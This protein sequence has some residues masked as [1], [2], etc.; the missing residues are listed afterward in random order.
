MRLPA[1]LALGLVLVLLVAPATASAK[2]SIAPAALRVSATKA[3]IRAAWKSDA[4]G[5]V[6]VQYGPT[7]AYG[8][9]ANVREPQP[10][11]GN[12]TDTFTLTGLTPGTVYHLRGHIHENN[13]VP[14]APTDTFSGDITFTTAPLG[15]SVLGQTADFTGAPAQN[16]KPPA[17]SVLSTCTAASPL[18]AGTTTMTVLAVYQNANLLLNPVCVT[19]RVKSDCLNLRVG[20]FV[21]AFASTATNVAAANVL[22]P[23]PKPTDAELQFAVP[24]GA[25]YTVAISDDGSCAAPTPYRI[26][27]N[28]VP[29][30]TPTVAT[31]NATL[32]GTRSATL[33]GSGSARFRP[34]VTAR[35]DYGL[36]TSYGKSIALGALPPTAA[37]LQQ[38]RRVTGL[39]PNRVYHARLVLIGPTGLIRG[40]DTTFRTLAKQ[41]PLAVR[42]GA[43][44]VRAAGNV[45]LRIACPATTTTCAG[46]MTL[47]RTTGNHARLGTKAFTIAGGKTLVVT[48]KLSAANRRLL[49][50][51]HTLRVAVTLTGRDGDRIA[52]PTGKRTVRLTWRG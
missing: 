39:L 28:A 8:K 17:A 29:L 9:V 18:V 49:K 4:L 43:V 15:P 37:T 11:T 36:T 51:R 42:T 13:P 12:G 32:V 6:Q 26:D 7:T 33:N 14:P 30:L 50:R 34:G 31:A 35:F 46:K 40:A 5:V 22:P 48:V 52:F 38:A 16:A 3:L 24:A 41:K 19:V 2:S 20:G 45:P 44:R 1:R 23:T 27:V 47:R 21:G 10:L 25:T